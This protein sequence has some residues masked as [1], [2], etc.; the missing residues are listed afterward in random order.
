MIFQD[1]KPV[2]WS[3]DNSPS[4]FV[5]FSVKKCP[6]VIKTHISSLLNEVAYSHPISKDRECPF[7]PSN[8]VTMDKGTGLVHTAPNHG[9]DDYIVMKK[10]QIPLDLELPLE[11]YQKGSDIMDIWFDSGISWKC[12]LPENRQPPYGIDVLRWWVASHACQSENIPVKME[13]LDDCAQ[14]LNKVLKQYSLIQ[15]KGVSKDVLN[16]V[17]NEVSSFYCHLVKDRLYC[18]APNS[19]DR[20]DCQAVLYFILN[21]LLQ[22]VGPICPHLAEE[23][24]L[25]SPYRKSDKE[26]FAVTL[27]K[28]KL[29]KCPRC[30]LFASSSKDSLCPRCSHVLNVSVSQKSCV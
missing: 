25:F 21:T 2:F 12:V 27:A 18:D 1:H 20:L 28:T 7:L 3:P 8:H 13:I 26:M 6:D 24:F 22:S 16:F 23:V 29:E 14:S 5:K 4:L 19:K 15:Y 9:L 17:T 10:H 30:R 11:E